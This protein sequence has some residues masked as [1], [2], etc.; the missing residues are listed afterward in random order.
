MQSIL[1]Q[2]HAIH[3]LQ[4]ALRGGRVHHAWIF[5][6]PAGVGKMTTAEAFARTLLCHDPQTGESGT[7]APCGVCESCRL[8]DRPDA[9]HPDLHIVRK[10]LAQYSEDRQTRERKLI[11]IPLALVREHLIGPAHRS[12]ALGHGKVFLVDEAELLAYGANAAQNALLKT[13]EEPPP[14][15][16]IILVTA[17]ENRLLPTIRSRC[18]RV[19]F[20]PLDDETVE[21]W[22]ADH[23][24][25]AGLT[26]D[27]RRWV[28]RFARG[29]IGR[30]QLAARY[31]LDEWGESLAPLVRHVAAGRPS[32]ELGKAMADRVDAFAK[33][34]VDDHKGASKDA[35]NKAGVRHMLGLLGEL[36][37]IA[38]RSITAGKTEADPAETDTRA[39]PW[40]TG[41]D[42]LQQAERQLE[43]NVQ[44]PLLLDNLAVQW[45]AQGRGIEK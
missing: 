42:L 7:P 38:L 37:R 2:P 45:A 28:L 31:R 9:A 21:R 27:Q 41:V 36:C 44:A 4:A 20:G 24:T 14:G 43:S 12:A 30:A 11:T 26:E 32:H 19:A 34:W 18:Q 15:T 23:E 5:H 17:H 10:E 3:V 1:G 33:Q 16:Y 29:S 22:L 25:A 40:L 13:L 6:G 8:L 39:R 35:A